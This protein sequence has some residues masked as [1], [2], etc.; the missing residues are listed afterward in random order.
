MVGDAGGL[1]HQCAGLEGLL[2]DKTRPS[3]I[4]RLEIEVTE[5]V[6]IEDFA[7]PLCFPLTKRARFKRSI[8]RNLAYR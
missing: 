8:A 1:R 5:G 2:R 6:L 3:R 4:K 7:R